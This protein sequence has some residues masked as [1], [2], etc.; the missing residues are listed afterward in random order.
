M[1]KEHGETVESDNQTLS[2]DSIVEVYG[3]RLHTRLIGDRVVLH[4]SATHDERTCS[5]DDLKEMIEMGQAQLLSPGSQ[6]HSSVPAHFDAN[7]AYRINDVPNSLR[8]T[9][10]VEI[11][12]EKIKWLERIKDKGYKTFQDDQE[13]SLILLEIE[14]QYMEKCPFT[15]S[16]LYKTHLNARKKDGDYRSIFPKFANRGGKGKS[17]L[18]EAIDKIVYEEMEAAKNPAFGLLKPAR[19]FEAIEGRVIQLQR[20]EP[21]ER[22]SM[23]SLPTITRRMN[24]QFSAKE[25]YLRKYG[26]ERT[27]R[28]FRNNGQRIRAIRPLDIVEFD[29]KD[30]AC[31]L[32]DERT[33]L[34]WGRAYLTAGVDQATFSVLGINISEHARS[35]QSAWAA[36]EH[37]TYPKDPSHPDFANCIQRWEPYGHIGTVLLDN[38]SYNSTSAFQASVLESGSEMKYSKPFVP[39]NKANVEHF[40]DVV[41][42]DHI[43]HKPGWVGG[44]GDRDAL[45][46][47][48][49]TAVYSLGEFKRDLM[50]W[51]TDVYSNKTISTLGMSPREAWAKAF[52][53]MPPQLPRKMPPIAL[54]GTIRQTLK[55]R[56]SG[57]LLRKK[58]RYQSEELHELTGQI[59]SKADYVVRFSPNDLSYILVEDPRTNSYMRVP[60]IEDP[61]KYQYITD[62]QQSL[63]LKFCAASRKNGT[64]AIDL[65]EGRK[66]LIENTKQQLESKSMRMRKAAVRTGSMPDIENPEVTKATTQSRPMSNIEKFVNEIDEYELEGEDYEVEFAN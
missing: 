49:T 12:L 2:N 34:P 18:P 20:S 32:I 1:H 52:E 22:Y 4:D 44:K 28:Q 46:H 36:F 9:A 43:S 53:Y 63:I 24:E 54:A 11:W 27:M 58:L 26:R 35:T 62:F 31:F 61:Q 66:R 29:D 38:A 64:K 17:R 51:I 23:P 41:V 5:I 40:N 14:H 48:L 59:G 25:I 50:A 42:A 16:T 3:R 55:Q 13:F 8:S 37:A 19:I 6:P 45:G 60:C 7:N 56:D 10:A 30:T 15:T 47:G 39:T 57:G 65:Y 21:N 33:H